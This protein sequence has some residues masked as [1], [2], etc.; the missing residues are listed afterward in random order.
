MGIQEAGGK[1][2]DLA[3]TLLN[4]VYGRFLLYKR[5]T[6]AFL[7]DRVNKEGQ[8]VYIKYHFICDQGSEQ[9]IWSDAVQ[10]CGESQVLLVRIAELANNL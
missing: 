1:C 8:F 9:L 5:F 3:A 6:K 7:G 2:T 10:K 4:G